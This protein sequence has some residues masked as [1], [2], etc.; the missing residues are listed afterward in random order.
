MGTAFQYDDR[1]SKL[2]LCLAGPAA[3]STG[4]RTRLRVPGL[5]LW[6]EGLLLVLAGACWQ[7]CRA[8]L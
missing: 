4:S 7:A 1:Q 5:L 2:T 3:G 8:A 6:G